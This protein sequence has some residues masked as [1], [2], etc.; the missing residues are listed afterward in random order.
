MRLVYKRTLSGI[1]FL[2]L[3]CTVV[4]ILYF[5]YDRVI[6]EETDVLVDGNLS[7]NFVS[8]NH[9]TAN[10]DFNF[11]ITNNSDKDVYYD[12]LI[13]ELKGYDTQLLYSLQS[14]EAN[15]S[16]TDATIESEH[17]FLVE[18]LFILSGSTQNF[19]FTLKN[20]TNTTF[21][22]KIKTNENTEEYFYT[23]ILKNNSIKE[24]SITNV[25]EEIAES[26]E[27]LLLDVDDYGNTYYFRGDVTNNYVSFANLTWRIIRINGDGTVRLILNDVT[28]GLSNFHTSMEGY[29]DFTNTSMF[30]FL[31]SFYD[32]SLKNYDS[33]IANSSFCLDMESSIT[34]TGKIYNSY[35][36][37]V[38]NKIPSFN[39]LGEKYK[40]KIGLITADEVIYAGASS[41]ED[42]KKYYLYNKDFESVWWT[43]NLAKSSSDSFYP[44]TVTID[45]K[46]SNATNGTLYRGLRPVINLNKKVI[47]SGNGTITDPYMIIS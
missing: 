3:I 16:I 24:N 34:N 33:Y 10:G 17:P 13:D 36:R 18:H 11:S 45:G 2:I 23:T 6:K 44:F 28:S 20:N 43:S 19:G 1:G 40:S 4:G 42:N 8:G 7:A 25:G 9:I 15:I 35:S 27:G 29:E 32:N 37:L 30:S 26:N 22:I 14:S 46:L 5:F 39:C 31:Q 12:I 38:T 41:T 21:Q 47:V